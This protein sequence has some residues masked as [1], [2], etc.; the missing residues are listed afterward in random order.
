MVTAHTNTRKT[1]IERKFCLLQ[2]TKRSE[3]SQ[4]EMKT[5]I[6]CIAENALN[7]I[8]LNLIKECHLK[9]Y[10][11]NFFLHEMVNDDFL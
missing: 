1:H 4:N 11:F 7:T 5:V 8:N 10:S 3:N 2:Q 9:N 6:Y